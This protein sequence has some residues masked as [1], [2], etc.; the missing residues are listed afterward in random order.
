M[1]AS[2]YPEVDFFASRIKDNDN[3]MS[4]VYF[5]IEI[6]NDSARNTTMKIWNSL[7]NFIFMTTTMQV[8]TSFFD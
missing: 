3:C 7:E 6:L 8:G 1:Y 4:N 2:R 5:K